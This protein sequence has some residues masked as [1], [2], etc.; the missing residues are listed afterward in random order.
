M[1]TGLVL[2]WIMAMAEEEVEVPAL[3]AQKA[4]RQGRGT[5]RGEGPGIEKEKKRA[6]KFPPK[7]VG[8]IG[9][10][11]FIQTAIR[12]GFRVSKPWG[13]SDA[14][15]RLRTGTEGCSVCRYAR[16]SIDWGRADMRCMPRCMW[17]GRL[18]G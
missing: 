2:D 7:R 15:T 1:G 12:K 18:W 16:P 10:L 3:S 6:K 8:E 9:E 4:R 11:E 13:D 14:T 17:G 5:R